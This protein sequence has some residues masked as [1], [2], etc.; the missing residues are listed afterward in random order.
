MIEDVGFHRAT[1]GEASVVFRQLQATLIEGHR[2]SASTA[3]QL[4]KNLPTTH[5]REIHCRPLRWKKGVID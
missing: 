3:S 4:S 1:D 5:Q 2:D